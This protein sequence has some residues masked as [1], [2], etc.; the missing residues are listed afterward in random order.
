MIDNLQTLSPDPDRSARTLARCRQRLEGRE[1]RAFVIE[2]PIVVGVSLVYL[3]A[4]VA[5]LLNIYRR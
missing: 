5:D 2:R 4:V 3:L 1:P